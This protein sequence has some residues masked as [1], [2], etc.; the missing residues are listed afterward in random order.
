MAGGKR[1]YG[2][3]S[4]SRR[5]TPTATKVDNND[6][7]LYKITV[8]P[9]NIWKMKSNATTWKPRGSS[10]ALKVDSTQKQNDSLK[11]QDNKGRVENAIIQNAGLDENV[12]SS[13]RS[14]GIGSVDLV[15]KH[16]VVQAVENRFRD[17]SKVY[18]FYLQRFEAELESLDN[19]IIEQM[20]RRRKLEQQMTTCMNTSARLEEELAA[21]VYSRNRKQDKESNKSLVAPVCVEDNN[22]NEYDW[23][24]RVE[25]IE[26][27]FTNLQES[28][29]N[30]ERRKTTGVLSFANYQEQL[31]RLVGKT[32]TLFGDAKDA[33]E[34][35]DIVDKDLEQSLEKLENLAHTTESI[36]Q[37]V[38]R[39]IHIRS[40]AESLVKEQVSLITKQVCVEM[41]KITSN[42]LKE[43]NFR[44]GDM[45]KRNIEGYGNDLEVEFHDES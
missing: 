14:D 1:P 32:E 5:G 3:V 29:K 18:E 16:R 15:L 26:R 44:I 9:S 8:H 42:I 21:I 41:R 43:N 10:S 24:K 40:D 37:F 19:R 34:K 45:L 22:W 12:N 36:K 20:K 28:S 33:V 23:E 13:T 6:R 35:Q 25:R 2:F 27:N 4:Q 38:E 30:R 17:F 39:N 31:N 7:N 11:D